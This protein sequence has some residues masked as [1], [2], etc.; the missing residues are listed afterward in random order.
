MRK[1]LVNERTS[2]DLTQ[3]ELAKKL[4]LSAVYVRKIEKGDRNPSIKTMKKYQ[5][6]FG[7][8]VTELFPDIFNEFDDTKCIK[9]TEVIS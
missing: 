1:R 3:E 7:V 9:N 4:K 5:S 8:R 6:F 2:R